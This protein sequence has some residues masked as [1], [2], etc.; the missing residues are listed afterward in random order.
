MCRA[1]P[2]PKYVGAALLHDY[3]LVA[4]SSITIMQ[5]VNDDPRSP[6]SSSNVSNSTSLLVSRLERAG[7]SAPHS[8]AD[9]FLPLL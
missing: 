3:F 5:L 4:F 7:L 6:S 8:S 2:N 1:I 9:H